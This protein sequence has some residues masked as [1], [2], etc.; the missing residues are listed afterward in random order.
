M[1]GIFGL[2][3]KDGSDVDH[4]LVYKASQKLAHR[5]PDGEGFYFEANLGFGHRRLSILDLSKNAGQP[6]V[7]HGCH[8]IYNGEIYNYT[9]LRDELKSKGYMFHTNCD[10]E[11]ILS[12]YDFWGLEM[13]DRFNGMWAFAILDSNKN[14]IVLSRD[15]Y[16]MKPLYLFENESILSFASEIKAFTVLPQWNGNLNKS[17]VNDF[18]VNGQLH[19]RSDSFYENV[20][21][22]KFSSYTI[23]D[24]NGANKSEKKFYSIP[25]TRKNDDN[26]KRTYK[27]LFEKAISNHYVSDV[28]VACALSG[29]LDSSS[30]VAESY[31][32]GRRVQTFTYAPSDPKFSEYQYVKELGRKYQLIN[33]SISPNFEGHIRAHR[34]ALRANEMPS[35][36][37]N[38]I[39]SY[40]LYEAVAKENIKVLLAGQGAD[41]LLLGY[42]YYYAP[43]LKYLRKQSKL[44][45]FNEIFAL[46]FKYPKKVVK[47]FRRN[48]SNVDYSVFILDTNLNKEVS[49]S[50]FQDLYEYYIGYGQLHSLLQFEDRLSMAHGVESRLPFLDKEFSA[51]LCSLPHEQK[52]VSGIRKMP[53]RR[54][55]KELVPN[56]ILNRKDKMG[57][58]S[59][60]SK[61]LVSNENFILEKIKNGMNKHPGWINQEAL[62]FMRENIKKVEHHGFIWRVYSFYEFLEIEL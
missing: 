56:R 37:V 11:V 50:V 24:R 22:L 44:L 33:Q 30:I 12:A 42:S 15:R 41:E 39:S 21:Q 53:L 46:L 25:K 52:I 61:W 10:T 34:A 45:Y 17:I 40:L 32:K 35:L 4:N 20:S 58:L 16:G 54:A 38:L 7:K 43:F 1:C 8:I 55:M 48:L 59:P 5:G 13:L 3:N 31:A 60:Q 6:F 36:S 51:F 26:Q 49:P 18:L 29:G 28:E 23:I 27:K 47:V 9:V 19:H 62:T 2:I 14:E 57:Y